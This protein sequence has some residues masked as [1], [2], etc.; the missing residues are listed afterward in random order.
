[1][2]GQFSAFWDRKCHMY[3][4]IKFYIAESF[5]SR[6][7]LKWWMHGVHMCVLIDWI[8]SWYATNKIHK[9]LGRDKSERLIKVGRERELSI[10]TPTL[11][12]GGIL[13]FLS[14][15]RKNSDVKCMCS[16]TRWRW[17]GD[18]IWNVQTER[19]PS[20]SFFLN[21]GKQLRSC[22]EANTRHYR[23]VAA[24]QKEEWCAGA[25]EEDWIWTSAVPCGPQR[26]VCGAT[27][28]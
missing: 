5:S 16:I 2:R 19:F 17:G 1:M 11:L 23:P 25:H 18:V 15:Q 12:E 6:F 22:E 27:N 24:A 14:F 20:S 28:M 8:Y 7:I 26:R 10:S 21:K 4:I 3:N 13:T 9:E